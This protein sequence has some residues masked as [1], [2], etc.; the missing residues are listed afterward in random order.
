MKSKL[1]VICAFLALTSCSTVQ[2]LYTDIPA[3]VAQA[4]ADMTLA[5][6]AAKIYDK[7]PVCGKTA[8]KICRDVQ[9]DAKIEKYIDNAYIAIKAAD[10]AQTQDLL[11]AAIT[12]VTAVRAIT[13]NLPTGD[14]Q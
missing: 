2:E 8:A 6:H 14:A 12:A 5:V 13:D 10:K 9:V 7:L 1:L 11:N 4:E 3:G